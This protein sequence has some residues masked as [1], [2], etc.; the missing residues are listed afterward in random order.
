[1]KLNSSEDYYVTNA[2]ISW[3]WSYLDRNLK[4]MP[5][6]MNEILQ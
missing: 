2:D 3:N 5:V 6:D 4:A 1:L